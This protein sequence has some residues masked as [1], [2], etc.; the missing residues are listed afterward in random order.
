MFKITAA[1]VYAHELLQLCYHSI[2]FSLWYLPLKIILNSQGE[3]SQTFTEPEENNCKIKYLC[4]L[5]NQQI[6]QMLIKW[7][8]AVKE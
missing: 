2:F 8:A 3:Y 4:Y 6:Y 5:Y 7:M 1:Y